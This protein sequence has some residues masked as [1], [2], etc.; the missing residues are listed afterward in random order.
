MECCWGRGRERGSSQALGWR[1]WKRW[2][3]EHRTAWYHAWYRCKGWWWLGKW[4]RIKLAS[5]WRREH[6]GVDSA[7]DSGAVTH[8]PRQAGN[9]R[10]DGVKIHGDRYGCG[11]VSDAVGGAGR[12]VGGCTTWRRMR[13]GPEV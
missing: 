4:G 6:K 8:R 10:K 3:V 9:T 13:N 12:D 7:V 1:V 11:A 2:S 5:C